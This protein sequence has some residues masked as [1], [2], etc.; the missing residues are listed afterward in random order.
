MRDSVGQE[1]SSAAAS[2]GDSTEHPHTLSGPL[3]ELDLETALEE[4][5]RGD[6]YQNGKPSGR[7][8][9]KEPDLRVV[10]FAFRSGARMKEHRASGPISVQTLGGRVRLQVGERSVELTPGRLLAIEPDI[11]HDV[12][13]L[14]DSALLL[15]IGRTT[16]EH[17]SDQHRSPHRAE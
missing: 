8:L 11:P 9:V 6:Q 17:V 5:R 3:L 2:A 16:Y 15:T 10:V 1:P 14:E 4:L 7:T 13:A 12:E